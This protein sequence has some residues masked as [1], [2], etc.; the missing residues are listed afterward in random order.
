[1]C[2]L[3]DLGQSQVTP[4]PPWFP[5]SMLSYPNRL[6]APTLQ[7]W[8]LNQSSPLT[9]CRKA[10]LFSRQASRKFK[11]SSIWIGFYL[12]ADR[13]ARLCA[14]VCNDRLKNSNLM[15]AD[16]QFQQTPMN[17]FRDSEDHHLEV[18]HTA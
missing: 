2:W 12:A 18:L 6:L 10:S 7:I 14:P 8:K 4:L 11:K 3:V 17:K 1:M 9:L 5:A 16:D 15:I 13:L